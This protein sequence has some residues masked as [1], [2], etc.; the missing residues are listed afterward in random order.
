MG[1]GDIHIRGNQDDVK[2]EAMIV[3][4]YTPPVFG[5]VYSAA[6]QAKITTEKNSVNRGLGNLAVSAQRPNTAI[7]A[8]VK[9]A[10]GV[11][12]IYH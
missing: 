9:N 8:S 11:I 2:D 1:G 3:A 4:P 10:V 12:C 7:F 5:N 6:K